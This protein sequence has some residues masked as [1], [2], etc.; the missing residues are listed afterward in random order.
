MALAVVVLMPAVVFLASNEVTKTLVLS[1]SVE[2]T[3][4]APNVKLVVSELPRERLRPESRNPPHA[5]MAACSDC[6]RMV[7]TESLAMARVPADVVATSTLLSVV[8]T[9]PTSV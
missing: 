6:E 5:P 1:R 9:V 3:A 8:D 4:L 7:V 2:R